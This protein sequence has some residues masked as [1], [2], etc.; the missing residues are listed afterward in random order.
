MSHNLSASTACYG[1]ALHFF[2]AF[3]QY[4]PTYAVVSI[5]N[6]HVTHD[7]VPRLYSLDTAILVRKQNKER[8]TAT[9]TFN[10][11]DSDI[12]VSSKWDLRIMRGKELQR[13][14]QETLPPLFQG[15]RLT[16]VQRAVPERAVTHAE[17]R[18]AITA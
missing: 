10:I 18:S 9:P 2:F 1:K 13:T 8:P 14:R 11:V 15:T 4:R 16:N 3:M 7:P 12:T 17:D 6:N 5:V